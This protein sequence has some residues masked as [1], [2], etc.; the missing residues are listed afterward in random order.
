MYPQMLYGN[1]QRPYQL[2]GNSGFLQDIATPASV[3]LP[4]NIALGWN[5]QETLNRVRTVVNQ[6]LPEGCPF[7]IGGGFVRDGLLGG[8]I[9]DIDIWL[10]ENINIPQ[11][12]NQLQM[13]LGGAADSS[14][15]M[16]DFLV[17]NH[18]GSY[19][20]TTPIFTSPFPTLNAVAP[21]GQAY[22]DMSNHWVINSSLNGYPLQFMRTNVA[23]NGDPS[24]FMS[25]LCRNFDIDLCMMFM[26]IERTA[27]TI[28]E[29]LGSQYIIMPTLIPE[30]LS[31]DNQSTLETMIWNEARN[32]TSDARRA[33]RLAKMCDKYHVRPVATSA[34]GVVSVDFDVVPAS[35]ITAAPVPIDF[36]LSHMDQLPLPRLEVANGEP[37]G[38]VLQ[39]Q[40]QGVDRNEV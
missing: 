16:I 37:E 35:F 12:V 6:I 4:E 28:V 33:S 26:C 32:T 18:V 10:P 25:S 15:R 13:F 30:F 36:L 19:T 27:E 5:L 9:S 38:T 14:D 11:P 23:W 3:G 24:E 21:D 8:A 1:P 2:F 31:N 29:S 40:T 20:D 22:H 17:L 34:L 39:A 7:I